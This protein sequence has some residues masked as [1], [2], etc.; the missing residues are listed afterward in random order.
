MYKINKF[1]KFASINTNINDAADKE[2]VQ[3]LLKMHTLVLLLT[4]IQIL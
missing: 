1:E 2:G 4:K 3:R